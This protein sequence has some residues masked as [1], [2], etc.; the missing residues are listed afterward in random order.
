ML[1]IIII[2]VVKYLGSKNRW[3]FAFISGLSFS[4]CFPPFNID[5]H[6]ALAPLP[7]LSFIILIPLLALSVQK[8]FKRAVLQS[9]LYSFA[10]AIGQ[11][12]WLIFDTV[13]GLWHL[14]ILGL[15]VG[16]ALVGLFFLCAALLFRAIYRQFPR[17]YIFIF[18]AIWVLIDYVRSLGDLG[19]P[20][21][22]LGYSL[23]S[24]LPLAQL[25]SVTGVWG[26]TF[27]ILLGNMLFWELFVNYY[28]GQTAAQKWIHIGVFTL[29]LIIASFWGYNRMQHKP[30]AEPLKVSLLQ[31]NLDQFNWGSN[32][33]DT[34]FTVLESQV[35]Q[36]AIEKPDLIVS[37]ESSLL[38]FVARR[39]DYSGRVHNMV[40]SSGIPLIFGS[41]HWDKGPTGS[42]YEYLVYNTVFLAE[43]DK[44]DFNFYHKIKLVPFSEAL[45][46]EVNFPILSRVNLGEA[47]FQRGKEYT[48]FNIGKNVKAAPLIC[49]EAIFPEFVRE[50]VKKDANLLVMVT[51]DGWFGKST[52]PY[53]H[54]EMARMRAIENGVPIVRSANSGVSMFVDPYG[55]VSG[56][57][58]L[59][60]RTITTSTVKP[61]NL[62]TRYNRW[63]HW[64][65][66]MCFAIVVY[67]IF[68]A[69]FKRS[70]AYAIVSRKILHK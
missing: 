16:S 24:I 22:F 31:G 54:A 36:A 21:S 47:D 12:Y 6:W 14:I 48:V 56:R 68:Y 19:F 46:F 43:P 55:R 53:H 32:S 39:S 26:L 52:G 57:T 11:Y 63:G 23:T 70:G 10:V 30:D 13:D 20:W 42:F 29:F 58:G 1:Q 15:I 37:S 64:M 28:E 27:V 4:L 65:V 8:S 59:Y 66:N 49:Y 67:G 44:S 18:P 35:L 17:L 5:T 45:P 3:W 50:F 41:L 40:N 33:I 51:N 69:L 62:N 2:Q 61:A 60:T 9:Y 7:L 25:A 38:T 34:A